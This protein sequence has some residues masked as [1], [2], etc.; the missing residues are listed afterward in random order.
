M[1]DS[2]TVNAFTC[3][4][5]LILVSQGTLDFV[6]SEDELAAIVAH[7]IAHAV[8]KHPLQA[9][10][11]VNS[12]PILSARALVDFAADS[13][14][15]GQLT[16][17]FNAST[18]NITNALLET[19][20]KKEYEFDADAVAVDMLVRAGYDPTA[21]VT[22]LQRMPAEGGFSSTHPQPGDRM[23]KLGDKLSGVSPQS[24]NPNR[25]ARF[26]EMAAWR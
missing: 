4:A 12:I 17:V 13:T 15:L 18:D 26:Q 22:V 7:E 6:T 2:D 5:G 8:L 1:I 10:Q 14:Q 24:P 23:A 16:K 21:L 11:D 3:P 19:G 9:I 25:V 20:Y